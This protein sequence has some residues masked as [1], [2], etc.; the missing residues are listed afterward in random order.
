MAYIGNQ[1]WWQAGLIVLG[2]TI[3]W[4]Y[5][6]AISVVACILF[7]L[8]CSLQLIHF[9]DY[10]N[11]FAREPDSKEPL[12]KEPDVSILM[13]EHIRLRHNLSKISHRFRIYLLLVFLFVTASLFATLVQITGAFGRVTFLNGGNFAVSQTIF[14]VSTFVFHLYVVLSKCLWV[15]F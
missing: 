1:S 5:L 12:D 15:L 3:S 11:F 7:Y 9:H 8:S 2:L 13:T 14:S 10:M 4:T 6:S